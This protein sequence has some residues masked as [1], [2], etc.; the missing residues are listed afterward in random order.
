MLKVAVRFSA[1]SMCPQIIKGF[2][3]HLFF[4]YIVLARTEP[5]LAASQ[6]EEQHGFRCGRRLEEHVVAKLCNSQVVLGFV[7]K[8]LIESLVEIVGRSCFT[9]CFPTF[10]RACALKRLPILA[11]RAHPLLGARRVC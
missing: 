8:H 10:V 4:A 5:V 9:W 6:P 3:L 1:N 2:C 7:T 11:S